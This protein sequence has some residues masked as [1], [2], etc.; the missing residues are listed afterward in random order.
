MEVIVQK[1]YNFI[2]RERGD[3]YIFFITLADRLLKC[4]TSL[5]VLRLKTHLALLRYTNWRDLADQQVCFHVH[6]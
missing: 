4:R 3:A 1:G 5:F 2:K 6:F